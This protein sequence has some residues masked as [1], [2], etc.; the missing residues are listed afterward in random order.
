M[1][2]P[3]NQNMVDMIVY[4]PIR[5]CHSKFINVTMW[6]HC[7]FDSKFFDVTKFTTLTPLSLLT[8]CK[9]SFQIVNLQMSSIPILAMKSPNRIFIWDIGNLSNIFLF[10]FSSKL[11]FISSVLSSV[12]GWTFRTMISHQWPLH[13]MYD[14]QSLIDFTL[15]IADMILIPLSKEKVYLLSGTVPSLSHLT[16]C[17]PTKSKFWYLFRNWHERTCPVQ[18]SYIP[19]TKSH[20][21]YL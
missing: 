9:L 19:C 10:S 3:V 1:R 21:H 7:T 17:T 16:S 4:L 5:R 13:F 8:S 14:I 2:S 20:V 15:S 11:S 12:G 18:T 6:E